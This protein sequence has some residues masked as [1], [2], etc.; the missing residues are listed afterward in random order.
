MS[1]LGFII[2]LIMTIL[3]LVYGLL[4]TILPEI[5][6]ARS[7]HLYTDQSWN[8]YL[9]SSPTLANYMLILERM[10][11]GNGLAVDNTGGGGGG[12]ATAVGGNAGPPSAPPAAGKVQV[13]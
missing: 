7:F 12:G 4:A 2:L 9:S 11:G 13:L 1:L 5:F 6:V 8:E 3:A 10:A